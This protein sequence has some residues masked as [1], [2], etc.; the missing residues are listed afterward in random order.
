M[1][2][3]MTEA[4]SVPTTRRAILTGLAATG[5]SGS[6]RDADR[7]RANRRTRIFAQN[8]VIIRAKR[9]HG[10]RSC[11]TRSYRHLVA[12]EDGQSRLSKKFAA[13]LNAHLAGIERH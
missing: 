12:A 10:H 1:E 11:A 13:T 6:G 3:A 2:L 5:S 8:V 4:E 7:G 9:K